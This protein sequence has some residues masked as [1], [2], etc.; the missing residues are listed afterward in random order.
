M[1][2]RFCCPQG[3]RWQIVLA[4]A[5]GAT[6]PHVLCPVCGAA[7]EVVPPA[8][9]TM[10]DPDRTGPDLQA[11]GPAG[12]AGQPA[13]DGEPTSAWPAVPGYEI[14]GLLGRGGTGVVYRARHLKL[15]RV[16]ALKMMRAGEHAGDE[17]Q[18]RLR[19]EAEAVARMQHPHI[20]QIHEIGEHNGLPFLSL[21]FAEGG[22]LAQ[23]LA[24]TP[25]PAS[26]AAQLVETLARAMHCA[27]QR[28]IVPR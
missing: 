17:E 11:E 25:L 28:G 9:G 8:P 7:A 22:S 26:Q 10:A 27:H 23:K 16:V 20:V 2:R 12:S 21:E 19:T 14:L 4:D 5:P 15:Q 1:S 6:L 13:P 18:V 3:H 24:G